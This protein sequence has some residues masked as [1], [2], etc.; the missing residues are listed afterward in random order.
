VP[1]P[2]AI[3][4]RAPGWMRDHPGL[5]AITLATGL[6]PPRPL[7]TPGEAELLKT[8]ARGTRCVVEIGVYEGSSAFVFCEAMT[9]DAQLHLI[10]PFV[11]ES[12]WALRRGWHA[13]PRATRMAVGRHCAAG[14]DV[15]WHIARSQDVGRDWQGP[16][17]DLVFIDGDHSP[18]GCREDWDVWHPHVRQGGAVAF[19]DAR[20]D[21]PDG[22]GSPGPTSVAEELFRDPAPPPGWR[23]TD[24]LDTTVV[25][26]REGVGA[27]N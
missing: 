16:P 12:G 13:T 25:V 17:V 22:A 27:S 19:H 14:P 26:R 21:A 2:K 15:R 20:R 7:H 3:R 5:R 9:P 18:A 1:L 23:L 6:T 11:D 24:E 4:S 8:L 10:D